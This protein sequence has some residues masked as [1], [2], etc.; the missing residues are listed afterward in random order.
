[1][2]AGSTVARWTWGRFGQDSE[3]IAACLQTLLVAVFSVEKSGRLVSGPHASV[4]VHEA[5]RSNSFLLRGN[6]KIDSG[7]PSSA[8]ARH[9][10]TQVMAAL[11][12]GEVGSVYASLNL[13]GA[14]IDGG[15]DTYEEQLFRVGAT[16]SL[17]YVGADLVTP[18]DAW[19][20][21]ALKGR[22]QPAAYSMNAPRL[23]AALRDLDVVLDSETDP[24][25]PTSFAKPTATGVVNYFE[26]DGTASDAW[27]RFEIPYRYSAFTH[28]PGF[29]L[30]GY[31]RT[32]VGEVQYVPVHGKHGVAGFL[33]SC[34]AENAASFEP[35]DVGKDEVYKIGLL[36]LD[37]L[38][39]ACGRGL[40]PSRALAELVG[41]AEF[42]RAGVLELSA[43]RGLA[44]ELEDDA[45]ADRR[46]PR[47]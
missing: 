28:A 19:M 41:T 45:H 36:R 44:T 11:R 32:A 27:S 42:A 35:V 9:L 13:A 22:A 18:S 6:L 39:A 8:T 10:T 25:D 30:I 29:G 14:V 15:R 47:R 24:D 5:G 31:R 26:H 4:S 1:M 33:W 37:R 40:S 46:K 38:R 34:N 43:L 7:L 23:S 17:R 3:P 2:I 12:P 20:P 16:A 21:Y